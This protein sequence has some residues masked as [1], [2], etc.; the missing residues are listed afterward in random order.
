MNYD[1]LMPG[2]YM[3]K[4]SNY[5]IHKTKTDS[6]QAVIQISFKDDYGH[7]YKL[8]WRGGFSEKQLPFTLKT[9]LTCGLRGND[10]A[11]IADGPESNA[12][13]HDKT[14]QV[15]V[16]KQ[17]DKYWRISWINEAGLKKGISKSEASQALGDL[18]GKIA[19]LRQEHGIKDLP[20][21]EQVSSSALDDL[22]F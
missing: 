21:V 18:R 13:D 16:E 19:Q 4:I 6:L 2:S 8:N 1:Q 12:L 14:F 10:P 15:T 7:D 17:D 20:R 3:G 11:I 5:G 9:L 22:P